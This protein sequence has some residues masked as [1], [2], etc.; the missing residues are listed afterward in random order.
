MVFFLMSRL[1]PSPSFV[2]WN[3]LCKQFLGGRGINLMAYYA[4][5]TGNVGQVA[6]QRVRSTHGQLARQGARPLLLVLASIE[7][8]MQILLCGVR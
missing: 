5:D 4:S 8:I 1:I 7:H 2:E 6:A 3:F